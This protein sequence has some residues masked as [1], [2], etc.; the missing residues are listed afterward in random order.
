MK[1]NEVYHLIIYY[2]IVLIAFDAT[3]IPATYKTG[4]IFG[5]AYI[6][7]GRSVS[8]YGIGLYT[9]HGLSLLKYTCL[10]HTLS[11]PLFVAIKYACLGKPYS[12][13]L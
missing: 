6:R 2:S 13:T 12:Q 8:E 3:K 11:E 10:R 7:N 4:L 9:S 1:L 5:R